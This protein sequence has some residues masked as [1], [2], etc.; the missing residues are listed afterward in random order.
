MS[1]RIVP[2]MIVIGALLLIGVAGI[3]WLLRRLHP[4]R[5]L[6]IAERHLAAGRKEEAQRRYLRVVRRTRAGKGPATERDR[7]LGQALVRLGEIDAAAGR[8]AEAF[9]RFREAKAV[10]AALPAAAIR[11]LALCFAEGQDKS[12]EAV[13]AYLAA[14]P[15]RTTGDLEFEKVLLAL[16]KAC[17]ITEEMK[18]PVRRAVA[19]ISAQVIAVD[20]NLEW[21]HYFLGLA[22]LLEGRAAQALSSFQRA[23]A[24]NPHRPL[25]YYWVTV[26]YLQ[27]PEPNLDCAVGSLERF[28]S[29][30][31][32]EE[33]H[34]KREAR[35]CAEV[36]ARLMMGLG[37]FD[38]TVSCDTGPRRDKLDQV[39]RY[40]KLAVARQGDRPEH[41]FQLA[42]ALT[43][44]GDAAGAMA[45]LETAF[46]LEP[47]QKL[48]G[49]HLGVLRH[50][51]AD[52]A[53]AMTALQQAV[54]VDAE[55][56]D[57]LVLLGSI[58]EQRGDHAA[59]ESRL[60][61]GLKHGAPDRPCLSLLLRALF[62]QAKF[63]DV[64]REVEARPQYR[65][66]DA[67]DA[68]AVLAA[69]RAYARQGK[70]AQ[71]L[72]WLQPVRNERRGLYYLGCVHA[73]LA[74]NVAARQCF[75]ALAQET[76]AWGV[77]ARVQRGHVSLTSGD[78]AAA[79]RDY[80]DAAALDSAAHEARY[81]LGVLA[82]QR[83][84]L[85]AASSFMNQVLA[86]APG[87]VE[88]RFAL[89]LTLERRGHLAEAL[90]QY[91]ALPT[92]GQRGVEAALR[93]GVLNCRMGQFAQA[94]E[95][96]KSYARRG[97]E[98]DAL[99][100]YRGTAQ[101]MMGGVA[102]AIQDWSRILEH[103]PGHEGVSLNLARA[104]Y[105][106]GSL[107]LSA[108]NTAGALAAWE[109]YLRRCPNDEKTAQDLAELHFHLAIAELM[110]EG[111]VDVAVAA[112]AVRS[113]ISRDGSNARYEYIGALCDLRL[114]SY[115][116]CLSRLQAL[117]ESAGR[118][119]RFLYHVGL[120]L[121]L[122]GENAAAFQVFRELMADPSAGEYGRYATWAMANEQIREGKYP[123]ALLELE[124]TA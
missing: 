108:G 97:T 112:A 40:L 73:H 90:Q 107:H 38:T 56:V 102:E 36:A 3:V 104:L 122:K 35:A 118:Q 5:E 80:Q 67:R 6:A 49:Y 87:H 72:H 105:R 13:D 71:A 9:K 58:L 119:P 61:A 1:A 42:R 117:L 31:V 55:Y 54:A 51:A 88:A 120:C 48:H 32:T 2:V 89:A 93:M 10:R 83:N 69:A 46:R 41:H 99:L 85:D 7:L 8:S 50:R 65:P 12:A 23:C 60:R 116:Q 16:Q 45:H 106:L 43:L 62:A 33:K 57:A 25:T 52:L 124:G 21:P 92:E 64:V 22:N 95:C 27:Q 37:G 98:D 121:L 78:T 47:N 17:R 103:R 75:D 100:F 29:F 111:T 77:R 68:D 63:D 39:L 114:G 113:A 82:Y 84:D 28:L 19:E 20:P 30:P 24:L 4:G 96:L 34:Q 15:Y 76:D 94:L 66:S 53:G 74:Q 70:F 44:S 81:A 110:K 59:A 123:D 26:C 79:E 11:L 109:E 18:P 86:V 91:E 14:L 115:D 101:Y